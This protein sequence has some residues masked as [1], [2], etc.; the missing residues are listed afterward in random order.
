MQRGN[1][2]IDL[3]GGFQAHLPAYVSPMVH[4]MVAKFSDKIALNEVSRVS[5]WPVQFREY[6]TREDH[7]ALY[8]FAQ[9]RER[10]PPKCSVLLFDDCVFIFWSYA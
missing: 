3:D 6:G 2:Q 9:D 10:Y 4:E 5:I 8:F 1:K 7:I